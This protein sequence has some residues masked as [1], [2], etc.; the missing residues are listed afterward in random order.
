LGSVGVERYRYRWPPIGGNVRP[1]VRITCVNVVD[2]CI[3]GSHS[4]N[5]LFGVL[6]VWCIREDV[7]SKASIQ[8]CAGSG[9]AQHWLKSSQAQAWTQYIPSS[10]PS[11]SCH[12]HHPPKSTL[13][14]LEGPRKGD[15][16]TNVSFALLT[17]SFNLRQFRAICEVFSST[18]CNHNEANS[19]NFMASP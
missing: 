13:W 18:H 3:I 14:P 5:G 17:Q 16:W 1:N 7:I 15:I 8:H 10:G 4:D 11:A 12:W 9:M 19:L 2:I 6:G